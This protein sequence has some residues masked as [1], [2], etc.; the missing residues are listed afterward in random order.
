MKVFHLHS[1]NKR[2]TAH[3]EVVVELAQGGEVGLGG[4]ALGVG[5]VVVELARGGRA[6]A[7]GAAAVQVAG[8]DVVGQPGRRVV[9]GAAVV[10]QP[11]SGSVIRRRQTA[12]AASSRASPAGMGP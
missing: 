6:G 2:L 9:G 11:E 12:W 5:Q 1:E 3:L 4:G 10:E 7:A 8:A